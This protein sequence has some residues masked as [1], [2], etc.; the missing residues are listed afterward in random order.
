MIKSTIEIVGKITFSVSKHHI[1]KKSTRKR[2]IFGFTCLIVAF[3][4]KGSFDWTNDKTK[5]QHYFSTKIVEDDINHLE[6]II[7]KL[8]E[9]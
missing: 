5:I 9:Y 7:L 6:I 4:Q 1:S 8:L 2:M 3:N